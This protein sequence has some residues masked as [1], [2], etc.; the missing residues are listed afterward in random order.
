MSQENARTEDTLNEMMQWSKAMSQGDLMPR[1]Y[2]KKPANLLFAAEY[3][4]ALGIS[5]I[6]V[7]T[8]IAVIN[9][10]PSPSADLMSAMVRQHGHKLRVV[11][12]DTFAEATLIRSDDPDFEYK[13]RWDEKKARTAGLWG[14]KGPWTQYPAA[15]LRAR[16]I[17]EVVR[18]GASDVMAGGIYTPEEV[19]AL[20]D[21]SGQMV[22]PPHRVTAEWVQ[23]PTPQQAQQHIR[24]Q[25]QATTVNDHAPEEAKQQVKN[26]ETVDDLNRIYETHKSAPFWPELKPLLSERKKQLE[27]DALADQAEDI[28]PALDAE[29]VE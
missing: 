24:E 25:L 2:Q 21:E 15:M 4:D 1:Q 11:G 26:A 19:G 28:Q 18:M 16:A 6:H 17:S 29:V 5:R 14:N 8:S 3:A 27:A 7:L 9:G 22:E 12:D 23:E 10:R 20:V 13:A